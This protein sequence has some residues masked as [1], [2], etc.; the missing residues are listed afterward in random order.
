M[1]LSVNLISFWKFDYYNCF[2]VHCRGSIDDSTC[3]VRFFF[4][5]FLNVW[6]WYFTSI[7]SLFHWSLSGIHRWF[8]CLSSL[9]PF[10]RFL[11]IL[12]LLFGFH[13]TFWQSKPKL[14]ISSFV[15]IWHTGQVTYWHFCDVFDT[16][17][18]TFWHIL[19]HFDTYHSLNRTIPLSLKDS[20]KMITESNVISSIPTSRV[21]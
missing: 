14:I 2:T 11:D 20:R 10:Q 7:D 3:F 12:T 13:V 4:Y 6:F 15:T 17:L 16:G 5:F 19:W 18:V 21:G 8:T 9:Y 1:Q